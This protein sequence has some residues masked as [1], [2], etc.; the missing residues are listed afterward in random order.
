ML[1]PQG[2]C[3]FREAGQ[4]YLFWALF[5]KRCPL[6]RLHTAEVL[7]SNLSEPTGILQLRLCM[8]KKHYN[9]RVSQYNYLLQQFQKSI[10]KAE[11]KFAKYQN[12]LTE[13]TQRLQSCRYHSSLFYRLASEKKRDMVNLTTLNHRIDQFRNT[14]NIIKNEMTQNEGRK[15]VEMGY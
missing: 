15:F 11:D 1:L 3:L 5:L 9:D 13:G 7:S 14:L 8:E 12:D 4:I 6:R 2:F 10:Q